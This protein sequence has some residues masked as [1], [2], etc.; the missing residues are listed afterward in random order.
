MNYCELDRRLRISNKKKKER[1]KY[2]D[3]RVGKGH[4]RLGKIGRRLSNSKTA[5]SESHN[6]ENTRKDSRRNKKDFTKTS[7]VVLKKKKVK[8]IKIKNTNV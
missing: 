8:Q 5:W 1:K 2:E 3:K 6:I 7:D 4:G